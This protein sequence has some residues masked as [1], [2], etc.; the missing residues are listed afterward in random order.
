MRAVAAPAP[1][2]LLVDEIDKADPE[3]EAIL[4][5]LLSDF[6]VTVPEIGRI[7]ARAP[8]RDPHVEQLA[9]ALRRAQA[10]LLYL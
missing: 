1:V 3:F 6:Q 5:E 8:V 2:V 4:L 9:R 7:E 10:P